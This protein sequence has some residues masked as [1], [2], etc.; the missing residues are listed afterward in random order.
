M[1]AVKKADK[2]NVRSTLKYRKDQITSE[3]VLRLDLQD[4]ATKVVKS[5]AHGYMLEFKNLKPV[6]LTEEVLEETDR[7]LRQYLSDCLDV[8]VLRRNIGTPEMGRVFK[9]ANKHIMASGYLLIKHPD[10]VVK[11]VMIEWDL[12]VNHFWS[13]YGV[14]DVKEM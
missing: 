14:D 6:L 5:F 4:L 11:A 2:T 10:L 13:E 1:G 7:H 8:Y 3:F 12:R 9:E